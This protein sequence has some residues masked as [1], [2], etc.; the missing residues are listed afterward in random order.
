MQVVLAVES[1]AKLTFDYVT[2]S[3]LARSVC[4]HIWSLWL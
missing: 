3:A 4:Y 2:L 1:N